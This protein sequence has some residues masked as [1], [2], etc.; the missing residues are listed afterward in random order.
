MKTTTTSTCLATLTAACAI[1]MVAA[2]PAAAGDYY[3]ACRS[4]DGSYIMNDEALQTAA[5][6]AAGRARS[7]SYR[8]LKKTV[9]RET[10]GYCTAGNRSD[11]R[12]KRF[13]FL[14]RLYVL[15]VDFRDNGQNVETSLLCEIAADGLPAS[16]RCVRRVITLDWSA[17]PQSPPAVTDSSAP[18][19][20]TAAGAPSGGTMWMQNGSLMRL[21]ADGATRRIAYEIPRAGL[22]DRGVGPGEVLFEGRRDGD[23]YSGTAYIFTKSCGKVGYA[24]SGMVQSG[25]SRVVLVGYVPRLNA[26][27][28]KTGEREDKLVFSLKR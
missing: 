4:V 8:V 22:A 19:P 3:H 24:V 2:G 20:A 7:I 17:T 23:R 16:Y 9:L 5:D 1:T 13:K 10:Q 11:V 14:S 6:E 25:E 27:C 26:A 28:R 15:D 18:R 21:T 12:G